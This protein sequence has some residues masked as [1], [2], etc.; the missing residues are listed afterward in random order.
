MGRRGSFEDWPSPLVSCLPPPPPPPLPFLLALSSSVVFFF[1]FYPLSCSAASAPPFQSSRLSGRLLQGERTGTVAVPSDVWVGEGEG[2]GEG[3]HGRCPIPA[4]LPSFLPSLFSTSF[5]SFLIPQEFFT[6][7][8]IFVS[9]LH[10]SALHSHVSD[11]WWTEFIRIKFNIVK[12]LNFM[13]LTVKATAV[14]ALCC[15]IKCSFIVFIFPQ[16]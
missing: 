9:S 8:F 2:E 1:F 14:I 10:L 16:C 12:F 3:G 6:F 5:L 15:C 4:F 11:A 13:T 7:P